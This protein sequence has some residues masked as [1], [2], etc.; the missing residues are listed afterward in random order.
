[1]KLNLGKEEGDLPINDP[2]PA[3]VPEEKAPIKDPPTREDHE[4]RKAKQR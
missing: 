4:K 1:M 2:P 3:D